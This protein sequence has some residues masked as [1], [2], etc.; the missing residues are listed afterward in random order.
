MPADTVLLIV[1]WCS[2]HGAGYISVQFHEP[3]EPIQT[4]VSQN[5]R[6]YLMHKP[7]INTRITLK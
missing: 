3:Y 6:P 5:A 2:L 4:A 1:V 7:L